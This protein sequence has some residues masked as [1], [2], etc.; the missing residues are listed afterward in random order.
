M[1]K[2]RVQDSAKSKRKTRRM[3]R[4]DERRKRKTSEIAFIP[5]NK[6]NQRQVYSVILRRL[7]ENC[8]ARKLFSKI[9]LRSVGTFY[10]LNQKKGFADLFNIDNWVEFKQLPVEGKTGHTGSRF[11]EFF[12]L[13]VLDPETLKQHV[14]ALKIVRPAVQELREGG[15][16]IEHAHF[17]EREGIQVEKPFGYIFFEP[18]GLFSIFEKY[19]TKTLLLARKG[20]IRPLMEAARQL[21]VL[22]RKGYSMKDI[23][24]KHV[25]VSEHPETGEQKFERFFDFEFAHRLSSIPNVRE[26]FNDIVRFLDSA[27]TYRAVKNF[28]ELSRVLDEFID[29]AFRNV[30]GYGRKIYP[31]IK[32]QVFLLLQESLKSVEFQELTPSHFEEFPVRENQPHIREILIGI[33]R[34]L[35]ENK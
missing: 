1:A 28:N 25:F 11:K 31:E 33:N 27:I 9:D 5:L 35:K 12:E 13:V 3:Q 24:I 19:E 8:G 15:E 17:F 20:D 4:I 26:S 18:A 30:P 29:P 10:I 22:L 14:F 32:K 7:E 23:G 21:G 16:E 34:F 2:R 6:L